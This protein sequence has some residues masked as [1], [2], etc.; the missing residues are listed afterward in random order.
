M[1]TH[2]SPDS[3]MMLGDGPP[4]SVCNFAQFIQNHDDDR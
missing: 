3:L 4:A 2:A 1:T